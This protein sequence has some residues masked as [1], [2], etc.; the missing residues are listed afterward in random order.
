[1][2]DKSPD[3][4][5]R[6]YSNLHTDQPAQET[7]DRLEALISMTEDLKVFIKYLESRDAGFNQNFIRPSV[8]SLWQRY[9][10][11][12]L[13]ILEFSPDTAYMNQGERAQE[14]YDEIEKIS[15]SEKSLKTIKRW[16]RLKTDDLILKKISVS[17]IFSTVFNSE[18]P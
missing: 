12:R 16:D 15:M 18:Q 2:S 6:T 11:I 8:E 9:F 7:D 1:M 17:E 3:R 14:V 4:V 5:N 10:T 13:K